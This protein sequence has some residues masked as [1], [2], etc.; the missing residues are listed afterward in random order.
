M[1]TIIVCGAL[2]F[3]GLIYFA[4]A[5]QT[6]FSLLTRADGKSRFGLGF[7][8][9]VTVAADHP[10]NGWIISW[11][12]VAVGFLLLYFVFDDTGS[13]RW[14]KIGLFALV[15]VHALVIWEIYSA[16]KNGTRIH[17]ISKVFLV[18]IIAY[19]S[20]ALF[21]PNT[22]EKVYVGANETR[23][24]IDEDG[25]SSLFPADNDSRVSPSE[26]PRPQVR[27]RTIAQTL[28]LVPG[29]IFQKASIPATAKTIENITWDC[30]AGCIVQIEHDGDPMCHAGYGT[31][32][33]GGY[34]WGTGA[35]QNAPCMI[36][37]VPSTQ[38]ATRYRER[39]LMLPYHMGGKDIGFPSDLVRVG[40]S[41]GTNEMLG[42][43]GISVTTIVTE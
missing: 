43:I 15:G 36:T 25:V 2:V 37:T 28:Q 9:R 10:D 34:S 32:Y 18:A 16:I 7:L 30:K 38:N 29:G 40:Y 12:V 39:V 20:L 24:K 42:N 8:P 14:H 11:F 35:Y 31:E 4:I 23:K 13:D 6:G 21:F 17:T 19:W 41:F 26:S 22:A 27:V 3:L 33:S 5:K 1:S